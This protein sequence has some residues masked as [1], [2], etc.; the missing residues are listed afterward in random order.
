MYV[1]CRA[2]KSLW[3]PFLKLKHKYIDSQIPTYFCTDTFHEGDVSTDNLHV[4]SYG[5]KSDIS[6]HGNFYDR[7][8]QYLENIPTK[9]VLYFV[10]DM[11]PLAP[12]STDAL[13]DCIDLMNTDENIK[14][15]KLS[16]LSF[17][18]NGPLVQHKGRDFI[19]AINASDGYIM[20]VQPLL[21]RR[22][23]F[24]TMIK[25]CKEHNAR[26][27]QSGNGGLEIY[28]TEYFRNNPFTCLRVCSDIVKIN[29]DG[30]IVQSGFISEDARKVL[31]AEDIVID[32]FGNNL[33]FKL[34][35]D[36]YT[37]AGVALCDEFARRGIRPEN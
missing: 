6:V 11:F 26:G 32:T 25:Y 28:G 33:I 24:I 29:F 35:E 7:Y 36:E 14:S 34:T 3:A 2:Y 4:L 13:N 5:E 19:K 16:L 15:I 12:V 1:T 9:Y 37:R 31:L 18:F 17:P 21:L 20:N 22:D 23:F 10:D 8:L 27:N 30:G